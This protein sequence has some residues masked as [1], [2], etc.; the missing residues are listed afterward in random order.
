MFWIVQED[1]YNE[2]KYDEFLNAL[3]R[4]NIDHVLVKPIPFT[5]TLVNEDEIHIDDS[6]P[7]IVSG[8]VSLVRVAR[9]RGWLPGSFHDHDFFFQEW[10]DGFG[11]DNCLNG[12]AKIVKLKDATFNGHDIFVRPILDNKSFSGVVMNREEFMSWQSHYA[13]VERTD[14]F[15]TLHQDTEI[16]MCRP[17]NIMAEYRFF[18]ADGK[19]V[20]GSLYVRGRRVV[21]EEC[22]EEDVIE[23]TQSMVDKFQPAKAF[24]LD[25]AR[26]DGGFKIIEV[27]NFNSAGFYACDVVKII[28]AVEE[29]T[30]FYS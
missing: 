5:N 2:Y 18:V 12:H 1:L 22:H 4:M 19:V 8:S 26:I 23:F 7:I 20:T 25:V 30:E 14:E 24:V 16:M 17:K 13:Y 3:D 27:N 11:K 9:R 6:Q 15:Q 21:Y 28:N 10:R 29:M